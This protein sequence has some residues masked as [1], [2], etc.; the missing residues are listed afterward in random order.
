MTVV[1]NMEGGYIS[2]FICKYP[3]CLDSNKN[4]RCGQDTAII[5]M[6]T[7]ATGVNESARVCCLTGYKDR[8]SG[9]EV[10]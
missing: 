4:N 2:P 5:K 7:T 6:V 1:V 8:W 9:T 10:E 3:S